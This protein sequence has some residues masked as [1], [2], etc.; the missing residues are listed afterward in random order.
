MQISAG[1]RKYLREKVK[2]EF[3]GIDTRD[4]IITEAKD[5]ATGVVDEV[6][7]RGNVLTIRGRGIKI[8]GD[9]EHKDQVGVF[10]VPTEGEP[11]KASTVALNNPKTLIV[12]LPNELT[13]GESYYLAIETQS[14]IRSS[15]KTIKRMR[16]IRSEFSMVAA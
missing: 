8:E 6:V 13:E 11:I 2:L 16:G 10:F 5:E 14:S 1:L 7:T 12:Q 15:G 4:G 3:A 9:D